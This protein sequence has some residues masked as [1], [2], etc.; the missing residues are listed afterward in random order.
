MAKES[1]LSLSL[2]VWLVGFASLFAHLRD[3]HRGGLRFGH[4]RVAL[5]HP[6]VDVQAVHVLRNAALAPCARE[7]VQKE[8]GLCVST[9][10]RF[11]VKL[12]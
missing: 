10:G 3:R 7:K 8:R 11:R 9:R 4:G 2:V 6:L 12:F 1:S 5:A